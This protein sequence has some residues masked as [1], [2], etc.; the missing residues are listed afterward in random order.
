MLVE[1]H[2]G[3]YE[4]NKGGLFKVQG[5]KTPFKNLKNSKVTIEV[6]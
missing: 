5:I 3:V 4:I 1:K 6:H 2:V